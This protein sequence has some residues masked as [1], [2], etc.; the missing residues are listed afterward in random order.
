MKYLSLILAALPAI[1]Q[2][3]KL[4]DKWFV[5]TPLEKAVKLEKKRQEDI[6]TSASRRNQAIKA[7]RKS[8]TK[9]VEDILNRR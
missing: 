5:D 9:N 1:L 3:M 6:K 2:I 4:L 8:H 7:A